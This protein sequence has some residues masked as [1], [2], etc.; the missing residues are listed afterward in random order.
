MARSVTT[1]SEGN[2]PNKR[3]GKSRKTLV[4]EAI[5]EKNHLNM[6]SDSSS[7]ECEKAFFWHILDRAVCS[8]DKDSASLLK[9][10]LDKGW[11]S[12]KATMEKVSFELNKSLPLDGQASQVLV[13][14]SDGELP[15]DVG[16][17]IINAIGGMLKIKEVTELEDRIKALEAQDDEQ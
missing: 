12:P 6:N 16:I 9:T 3:R 7:D 4:L 14:V 8:E 15:P 13:A 11:P 10:L 1:F 17:S 5:R 2:Q